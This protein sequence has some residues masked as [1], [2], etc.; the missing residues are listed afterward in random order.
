[1][2][3]TFASLC[4][5]LATTTLSHAQS[6][7]A[8]TSPARFATQPDDVDAQITRLVRQIADAVIKRDTDQLSGLL[9]EEF[10]FVSPDGQK[11]TRAAVMESLKSA[12]Y[13]MQSM[14]FTDMNVRVYGD[15]AIATYVG[16]EKS[17]Y[18]GK[19]VSGMSRTTDIFVRRAGKWRQVGGQSTAMAPQKQ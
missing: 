11:L 2:I 16:A 8:Q 3:K 17:S 5:L 6:T 19:D 9:A 7:G 18:K 13:E 1:M 15:T 4:L 12:E 10:V 14:D